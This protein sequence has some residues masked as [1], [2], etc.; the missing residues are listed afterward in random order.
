MPTSGSTSYTLTAGDIIGYALKKLGVY[1][2]DE[3]VDALDVDYCLTELN[4]MLKAWQMTG[5]NLW[6]DTEGSL[7]LTSNTAAF[8]LPLAYRIIDARLRQNGR[9]L[10]MELL[11]RSEYYDMPLKSST[12]IPTQYYFDP[13][14][15]TGTLY[16]WPV[17]ASVS[18][19]T[20]EYT[21]Q[22]RFESVTTLKQEIDVPQEYLSLVGYALAEQIAPAFSVDA[23]AVSRALVGMMRDARSADREPVIRFEP[24]LR[25]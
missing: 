5:P 14:R 25:G 18:S 3:S 7:P 11:T 1:S 17:M 2:S 20:I 24:S 23:T 13:Q 6:R 19:E 4:V 12:G 9:D 8:S 22:R 21:Y 10:P 15:A 16:I